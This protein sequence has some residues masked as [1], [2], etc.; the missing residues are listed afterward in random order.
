MVHTFS[1]VQQFVWVLSSCL[2]HLVARGR[3]A[4]CG[5]GPCHFVNALVIVSSV[6]S[7]A[8]PEVVEVIR[9]AYVLERVL[10]RA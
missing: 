4:L 5:G 2:P 7:L 1:V 8:S 6:S 9:T 3:N 10:L